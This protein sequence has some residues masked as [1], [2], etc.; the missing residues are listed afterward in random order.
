LILK[1]VR[2][3][4]PKNFGL[5]KT[6]TFMTKPPNY[7]LHRSNAIP[8]PTIIQAAINSIRPG[9]QKQEKISPSPNTI[10]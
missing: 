2:S 9:G 8:N 7:V 3:K 5:L 6:T 1:K 10:A 4:K